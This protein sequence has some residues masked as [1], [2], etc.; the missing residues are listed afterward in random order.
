LIMSPVHECRYICPR[1]SYYLRALEL[2]QLDTRSRMNR[3]LVRLESFRNAEN[4]KSYTLLQ[5]RK[6]LTGEAKAGVNLC[7]LF[8]WTHEDI[9]TEQTERTK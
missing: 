6:Y 2:L 9:N 5:S 8:G 4:L 7:C 3:H 1:E